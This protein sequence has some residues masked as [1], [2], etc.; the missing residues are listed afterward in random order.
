MNFLWIQKKGFPTQI[1]IPQIQ[2]RWCRDFKH[3]FIN[4]EEE[5]NRFLM[6]EMLS[7]HHKNV[8]DTG[9]HVGDTGLFLAKVLKDLNRL[10]ILIY[11]I[12]PCP[13]KIKFIQS[14]I[15]LNELEPFTKVFPY[16]V[17]SKRT[18]GHIVPIQHPGM[19]K[20]KMTHHPSDSIHIYPL[21]QL[22]IQKV[23]LMHIDVEGFELEVLRG[24]QHLLDIDRPILVIES[25]TPF[26]E[27]FLFSL[28]YL[29]IK[30]LFPRDHVYKSIMKDI[31]H[32]QK[33]CRNPFG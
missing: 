29:F 2:D 10:D 3:R 11:M 14:M 4:H 32:D 15:H 28:G 30:K 19:W 9:A 18:F 7:L 33:Y 6:E 24:S 26:M 31:N 1:K 16:A 25:P 20:I 21:D 5:T 22:P 27:Q 13:E 23:G 17:G 12:E 8:I